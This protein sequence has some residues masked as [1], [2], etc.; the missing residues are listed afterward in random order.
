M[1]SFISF[2]PLPWY[3]QWVPHS[4]PS[5]DVAGFDKWHS[6]VH[7]IHHLNYFINLNHSSA[8][9][10]PN[11]TVPAFLVSPQKAATPFLQPF[12]L[13]FSPPSVDPLSFLW[14]RDQNCVLNSRWRCTQVCM[15]PDWSLCHVLSN[16][17]DGARHTDFWL[18][19]D[20]E[21]EDHFSPLS[22]SDLA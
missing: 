6:C 10:F 14:C 16:L 19:L 17:P 3:F 12:S 1:F 5:C 20:T 22:I 7:L 4:G 21:L 8:F 18:L 2:K 9:T 11:G 15:V 13:F